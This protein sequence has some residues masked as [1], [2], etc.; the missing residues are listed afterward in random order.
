MKHLK[1]YKSF[2]EDATSNASTT[3]GMG[4]VTSAQPG[5]LPG[6]TGTT[7]SGDLPY[8]GL[9]ITKKKRKGNASEVSLLNDLKPEKTNKVKE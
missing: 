4:S 7:G 6:T 8:F 2:N 1:T 9:P 3:A 5:S